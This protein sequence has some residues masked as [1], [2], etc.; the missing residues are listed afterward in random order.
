[1]QMKS[2]FNRYL[3]FFLVF[4]MGIAGC[5]KTA[6]KQ[7][8]RTVPQL[9]YIKARTNGGD[10]LQNEYQYD[11]MGKIKTRISYKDYTAGLIGSL[12]DYTYQDG[13]LLQI[14]EKMDF[15]SSSTAVQYVVGRST[16]VYNGNQIIQQNH[17]LKSGNNYEL[18]SFSVF[19]Y[20]IAGH[21]V[22]QTRYLSDGSLI[23]YTL[24]TFVDNN[25][26]LSEFY[27]LKQPTAIPELAIKSRYR[28]DNK[29]NPYRQV[30]QQIENIPFS[31]NANNITESTA[32]YYAAYTSSAQAT[33]SASTTTY[34]YNSMGYPELMKENGNSFILQYQ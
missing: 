11:D 1:M 4:A 14:D 20:D 9:R 33:T 3:L 29:K 34:Q 6:I 31:V 21:P 28:Y 13:R 16:F 30:Y 24:Y 2:G 17:Y 32:I 5:E 25:V 8:D 22:K 27:Q 26:V 12:A 18:R 23:G 19:T 7:N 10:I 15:S